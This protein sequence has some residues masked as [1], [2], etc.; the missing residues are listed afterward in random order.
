MS[1]PDILG[2]FTI[3]PYPGTYINSVMKDKGY[4]GKEAWK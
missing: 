3:V 2:L 4:L 1:P